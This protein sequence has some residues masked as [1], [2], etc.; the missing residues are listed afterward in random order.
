MYCVIPKNVNSLT[1]KYIFVPQK[2]GI[3]S[4][5]MK[6]A[7]IVC[8]KFCDLR[9]MIC[10][11]MPCTF[12][13]DHPLHSKYPIRWLKR[14][15]HSVCV[16]SG[17]RGIVF[18]LRVGL[19]LGISTLYFLE[20]STFFCILGKERLLKIARHFPGFHVLQRALRMS[21]AALPVKK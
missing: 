12:F 1:Q 2:V 10:L 6:N 9:N 11:P 21:A 4:F 8:Q 17:G 5:F 19:G 18:G 16:L 20:I 13:G 14:F 15:T 3:S 7:L